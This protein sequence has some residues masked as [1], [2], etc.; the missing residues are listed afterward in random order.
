MK[1]RT[2]QEILNTSPEDRV[3]EI[4]IEIFGSDGIRMAREFSQNPEWR[5]RYAKMVDKEKAYQQKI[6]VLVEQE[7]L[8]RKSRKWWKFEREELKR[9]NKKWWKF[10]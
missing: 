10:W 3:E 8:K 4:F 2:V 5:E 9:K 1:Y 7:E 6:K